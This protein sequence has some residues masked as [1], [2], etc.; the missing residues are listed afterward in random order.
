MDAKTIEV[1]EQALR[2]GDFVRKC[3]DTELTGL[4]MKVTALATHTEKA[5]ADVRAA[6]DAA[7]TA[8]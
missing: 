7:K 6:L 2:I 1:L 4:R 3:R 5:F 8:D